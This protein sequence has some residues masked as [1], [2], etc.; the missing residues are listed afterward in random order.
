L[1]S[2][3]VIVS[4]DAHYLWDISE[5]KNFFMLESADYSADVIRHRLFEHLRSE[6]AR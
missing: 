6:V 1:K 3:H 2:K 4:S 5:A